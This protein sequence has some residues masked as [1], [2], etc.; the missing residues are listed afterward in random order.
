MTSGVDDQ[1]KVIELK[2]TVKGYLPFFHNR[3][4]IREFIRDGEVLIRWLATEGNDLVAQAL[5][6]FRVL[7]EFK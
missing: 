5:L 3:I 1:K 2:K 4:Q 7:G 6:F